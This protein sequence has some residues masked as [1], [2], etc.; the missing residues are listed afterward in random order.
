MKWRRWG[1]GVDGVRTDDAVVERDGLARVETLEGDE[2][3][4]AVHS[5]VGTNHPHKPG[6]H[7]RS[8]KHAKMKA[9]I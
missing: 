1:D 7:Q 4:D 3:E 2:V 8:P 5:V 9:C 6:G